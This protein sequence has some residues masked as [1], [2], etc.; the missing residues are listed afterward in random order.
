MCDWP[1][2]EGSAGFIFVTMYDEFHIRLPL[3]LN[4][5]PY[6]PLP[7]VE[8]EQCR[9]V[10][11]PFT[12]S[13]AFSTPLALV[14][15]G[16]IPDSAVLIALFCTGLVLVPSSAESTVTPNISLPVTVSTAT[17]AGPVAPTLSVDVAEL[18]DRVFVPSDTYEYAF[19]L[20]CAPLAML[21]SF[22][23]S[24]ALM[25]PALPP[26][27]LDDATA[28]ALGMVTVWS[29]RAVVCPAAST[30]A[31]S[32]LKVCPNPG[33]LFSVSPALVLA[34]PLGWV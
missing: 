11:I 12:A 16:S 9:P 25:R 15:R 22:S 31:R 7:S 32:T 2:D 21:L 26:T 23:L 24:D 6:L 5:M 10:I 33:V 8:A 27:P 3:P 29:D 1:Y 18:A 19:W 4:A 13:S 20:T 30:V 34:P 14:S 28:V 17:V